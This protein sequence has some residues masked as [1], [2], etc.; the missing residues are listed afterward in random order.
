M[1]RVL[2]VGNC[3][4]DHGAIS[5]LLASRFSADVVQAHGPDDALSELRGG[6]FDL[7]LVNRKLD[8]DQSDG[9]EIIKQIKADPQLAPTPCM[10][11]TNF[12]EHQATAVAAGAEPGFGKSSLSAPETIERLKQYLK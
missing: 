2:D 1:K 5:D 4:M 6:K 10:L 9:L 8:Q 3:S 12:P 11:I 7:V